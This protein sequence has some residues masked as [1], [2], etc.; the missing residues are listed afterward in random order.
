MTVGLVIMLPA[1][2]PVFVLAGVSALWDRRQKLTQILLLPAAVV[3]VALIPDVG[4][5][6]AGELGL[7]TGAWVS[8]AVVILG[9]G[10]A[11]WRLTTGGMTRSRE[12]SAS[13]SSRR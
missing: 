7:N 2:I 5:A 12:L 10:W 4:W 13:S 8:L 1:W 3:L 6:L 11:L 9:A